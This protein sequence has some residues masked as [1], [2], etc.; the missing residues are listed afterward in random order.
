MS[1][2]EVKDFFPQEILDKILS[3]A[4]NNEFVDINYSVASGI[5]KKL[6]LWDLDVKQDIEKFCDSVIK[7]AVDHPVIINDAVLW[8]DEPGF[9]MGNHV[10]N[11]GVH[12]AI[13]IYLNDNDNFGT[14]FKMDG[15]DKIIKYGLNR[16]YINHNYLEPRIVHS[17]PKCNYKR[18]SLYIMY[19]KADKDGNPIDLENEQANMK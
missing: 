6:D 16:G 3:I 12:L 5:R 1:V 14:I 18:L 10:D 8:K 17:V 4:N 7:T 13:Q 15:S 9:S 11:Y 19:A 2:T